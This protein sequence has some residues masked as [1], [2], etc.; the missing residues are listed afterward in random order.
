MERLDGRLAERLPPRQLKSYWSYLNAGERTELL[1]VL[2]ATLVKRQIPVTLEERGILAEILSM[3]TDPDPRYT[4]VADP[5]GVLAQLEV[6][7]GS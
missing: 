6:S 3:Y 5:A 1:D 7:S 2:C 4:Y